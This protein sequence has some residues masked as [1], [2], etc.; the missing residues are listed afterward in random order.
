MHAPTSL[1]GAIGS[2]VLDVSTSQEFWRGRGGMLASALCINF[3]AL[4]D[5]VPYFS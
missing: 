2:N 1:H 5:E 4:T 3:D